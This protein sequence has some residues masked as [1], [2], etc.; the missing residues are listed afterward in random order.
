M[1][2]TK[3]ACG[4]TDPQW[5]LWL[6]YL[7]WEGPAGLTAITVHKPGENRGNMHISE[8]VLSASVLIT[9]ATLAAA[10]T[11]VGL[12]RLEYERVPQVAV[13]SAAF[14]IASLV[15]VPIGPSSVHLILNG[16]IGLLLGWVAFPAIL[17]GLVLQAV[18]F[19]YGGL[20][21]L[22]INTVIMAFPAV[23]CFLAFRAGARSE[24]AGVAVVSAFLCGFGAVFLGSLV[25]ALALVTSGESFL[26]VAKIIIIAHIPVM[27]IEGIITA[28]CVRFLKKVR[29]EMLEVMYAR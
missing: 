21:S 9:G 26:S 1:K 4:Q 5:C 15:H 8:G 10:G 22:G 25:A 12:K 6:F 27:I 19:Q 7:F 13:L 17:T 2:A 14:F 3:A 16:L 29:P 23:I 18:L 20:T 24:K 28:V 11:G